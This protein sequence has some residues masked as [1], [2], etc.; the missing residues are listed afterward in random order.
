MDEVVQKED[1][2][3]YYDDMNQEPKSSQASQGWDQEGNQEPLI[4]EKAQPLTEG[5]TVNQRSRL[6][7]L[8]M[9]TR[10]R[11]SG[12]FG[13]RIDRIG[14]VSGLGCNSGRGRTAV[15]EAKH[16]FELNLLNKYRALEHVNP[17]K[18]ACSWILTKCAF[19]YSTSS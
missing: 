14:N 7:D 10:K 8:L 6:Q 12:C 18:C 13:A 15:G 9:A 19:T 5:K 11:T 4:S 17:Q 1:L 3:A 16:K 2:E